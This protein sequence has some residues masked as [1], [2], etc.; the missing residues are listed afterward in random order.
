MGKL[1][2]LV[3]AIVFFWGILQSSGVKRL[4]WFFTG[5]L[6]FSDRIMIIE[7]PTKMS[8]DRL[9]IYSLMFSEI[10]KSGKLIPKI[11]YYPLV[12]S[13]IIFLVGVLTI[14]VFDERIGLVLK[15]YRPLDYFVQ[16]IF[17]SLLCYI[18]ITKTQ[19][20]E[21]LVKFLL[22]SSLIMGIYGIFNFFT[23]SNPLD[24]LI[25]TLYRSVSP[26]DDYAQ[27]SGRFRINSFV[28]HPIYYGYLCGIFSLLAFYSFFYLKQLKQ[29]SIVVMLLAT[30]NLILANSRTPLLAFAIGLIIFILLAFRTLAKIK[31]LIAIGFICCV[32]YNIPIIHESVENTVDAFRVN[33]G[34]TSGSSLN[35]RTLQLQASYNEFLKNPIFGNGLYYIEEDLGWASTEQERTSDPDFEG[36]ESYFY[37]LLIEQGSV[38]IFVTLIFIASIIS[39]LF[40]KRVVDKQI[41]AFGF[42]ILCMFLVFSMGTGT[43]HSWIISMGLIGICSKYLELKQHETNVPLLQPMDAGIK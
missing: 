7:F 40:K 28:S 24:H 38:G 32:I 1:F 31:M 41:S 2:F 18:N 5:I 12:S 33:G 9:L 20:W 36:F 19:D 35:M 30:T 29:L 22:V 17:V 16:T 39:Y 6:F 27:G 43:L 4:I 21:K 34:N 42:S 37:Q 14:G 10:V 3:A 23:L 8:F 26:F 25:T 15:I 13:M 11:K